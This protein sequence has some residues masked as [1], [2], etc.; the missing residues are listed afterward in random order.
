MWKI[1]SQYIRIS[2]A[3]PDGL[4]ECITCGKVHHY[5][6]IESGHYIHGKTKPTYFQET[7]VHPQCTRCN[8]YMSGNMAK[9]HEFMLEKYGKEEIEFLDSIK[10]RVEK[11]TREYYEEKIKDCEIMLN[12]VKAKFT[13]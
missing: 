8:H 13:T 11:R 10:H 9:Y 1:F 2:Y 4:V 7:N 12:Q 5:K 6:E 3:N